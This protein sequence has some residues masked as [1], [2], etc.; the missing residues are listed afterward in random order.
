MRGYQPF[1]RMCGGLRG[2]CAE[3]RDYCSRFCSA[4]ALMQNHTVK[5]A[6]HWPIHFNTPSNWL[7][8]HFHAD[9]ADT[10]LQIIWE[11]IKCWVSENRFSL[12]IQ[13]SLWLMTQEREEA[14]QYLS[15]PDS[16]T[17]GHVYIGLVGQVLPHGSW[18]GAGERLKWQNTRDREGVKKKW[19][20]EN[21][22]DEKMIKKVK[23]MN[24]KGKKNQRTR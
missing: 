19:K 11:N 6:M 5:I 9:A 17:A 10:T 18:K 12:I 8:I 20:K 3:L 13:L 15:P 16:R 4:T 7:K 14:F 22:E 1:P 21:S 24:E 2:T 23:E